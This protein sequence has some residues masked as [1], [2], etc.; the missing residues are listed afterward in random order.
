[1]DAPLRDGDGRGGGALHVREMKLNE[2]ISAHNVLPDV[3]SLCT[4]AAISSTWLGQRYNLDSTLG[5]NAQEIQF[6]CLG[7]L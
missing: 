2:R 4:P 1:M 5:D 7:Y 3:E 6:L